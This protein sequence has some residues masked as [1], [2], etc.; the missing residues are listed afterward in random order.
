MKKKKPP[1]FEEY[2]QIAMEGFKTHWPQL[3]QKEV[4]DFFVSEQ[5]WLQEQYKN[6]LLEFETGKSKVERLTGIVEDV[7]TKEAI[8][9]RFWRADGAAYALSLM[10]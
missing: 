2:R 7:G 8:L 4:D 10:Y 9:E 5:S 6:D 3:S 1:T